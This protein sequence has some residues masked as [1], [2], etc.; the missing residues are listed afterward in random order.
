MDVVNQASDLS[1]ILLVE[2]DADHALLISEALKPFRADMIH[3]NTCAKAIAE[4]EGA[5]YDLIILDMGLP[6]GSGLDVQD[7]LLRMKATGRV[8]FVT[9]DDTA[10]QAV[11]AM[12]HGASDYVIKRP[13]YLNELRL[14]VS[15]LATEKEA[16]PREEFRVRE[17]E[18]LAGILSSNDWNV[19]AT[20]RHLNMSRG[21]LRN[22]MKRLRLE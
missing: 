17:R 7:G 11:R 8:V 9:S 12:K 6:D 19:S 15:R 2:D 13:N 14:V 5:T 22:R 18:E 16:S 1:T 4:L 10:E 20:A 3:V 21:K